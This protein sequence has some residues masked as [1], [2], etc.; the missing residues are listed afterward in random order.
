MLSFCTYMKTHPL[1]MYH[2]I[3]NQPYQTEPSLY[4]D[5]YCLAHSSIT[6]CNLKQGTGQ[7]QDYWELAYKDGSVSIVCYHSSTQLSLQ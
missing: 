7:F 4:V 5:V 2:E 1:F 6:S 3:E